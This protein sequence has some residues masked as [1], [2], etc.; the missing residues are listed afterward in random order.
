MTIFKILFEIFTFVLF[1][2]S[3]IKFND[4]PSI[5]IF[6]GVIYLAAVIRNNRIDE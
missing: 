6:T 5:V 4:N 3:F 2:C 1:T